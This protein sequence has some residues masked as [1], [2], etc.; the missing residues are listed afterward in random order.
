MEQKQI[1]WKDCSVVDCPDYKVSDN[2]DVFNTLTNQKMNPGISRT[3]YRMICIRDKEHNR[4]VF[5]LGRLVLMVFNPHPLMFEKRLMECDHIDGNKLNNNISNLRWLTKIDN[6]NNRNLKGK[7]RNYH[8]RGIGLIKYE[9]DGFMNPKPV[10]AEIYARQSD[11]DIPYT[12]VNSMLRYGHYS[13]KYMCK[14][15][16]V[17]DYKDNMDAIYTDYPGVKEI[18]FMTTNKNRERKVACYD[19]NGNQ[20]KLYNSITSTQEDGF[21]LHMVYRAARDGK[22]YMKLNW[23]FID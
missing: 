18:V 10:K 2:G 15:F 9:L 11:P 7:K 17:D 5:N 12:V 23:K 22:P 14:A 13:K 20:V 6:M 19:D 16:Y 4:H 1:Q 8:E 21:K 3:G